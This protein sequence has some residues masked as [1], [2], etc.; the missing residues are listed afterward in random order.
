MELIFND[1]LLH[2]YEGQTK[3]IYIKL[4]H[5]YSRLIFD[6]NILQYQCI[7]CKTSLYILTYSKKS[8]GGCDLGSPIQSTG[9]VKKN[10][11]LKKLQIA[12]TNS[13]LKL[14]SIVIP[15]NQMSQSGEKHAQD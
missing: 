2:Q 12:L 1:S 14:K 4:K 8:L 6:N 3:K 13:I 11:D 5:A 7:L 10:W 9:W 15:L